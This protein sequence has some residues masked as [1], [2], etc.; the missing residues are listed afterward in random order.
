MNWYL[1]SPE[2]DCD[3]ENELIP[4]LI[5]LPFVAYHVRKPNWSS[6]KLTQWISQWPEEMTKKMI[7]H[8]HPEV[9]TSNQV[10]G[11]HMNRA[12]RKS[13]SFVKQ[14]N[15]QFVINKWKHLS[16]GFHHLDSLQEFEGELTHAWLSP[17]YESISKI[18]YVKK[19]SPFT[20]EKVTSIKRYS[21][22]ALGGIALEKQQDLKDKG[23]ENAAVKG[24]I[25]SSE[26][27]LAAA[28]SLF[29]K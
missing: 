7:I 24:F 19:W 23:F 5:H 2:S 10:L 25:W 9:A 28:K 14:I 6:E 27:P 3:I 26:N 21:V 18:S 1:I 13:K 17:V 29:N 22:V 16:T 12:Q 15:Q 4:K 8:Y 20:W 11:Y